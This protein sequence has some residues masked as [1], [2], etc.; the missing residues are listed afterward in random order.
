MHSSLV[1]AHALV[2]A[3]ALV[4]AVLG[5]LLDA[6]SL[7]LALKRNA[8]GAGPSG[9]AGVSWMLYLVYAM[10]RRNLGLLVALTAFHAACHWLLP[11]LHRR[12]LK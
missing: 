11:A 2:D 6:T 1:T 10:S 5:V 4:G 9:V 7:A 12:L 3:A 8:A